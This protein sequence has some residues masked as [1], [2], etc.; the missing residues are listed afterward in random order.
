MPQVKRR[1]LLDLTPLGTPGGARGIGRYTRELARG[2]AELPPS[3]LEGIELLALTSLG[4]A[5]EYSVVSDI[6]AFLEQS[7]TSLLE[8]RDYYSWA[9]RQR[10]AMWRAAQRLRADAVH[11][12]DPHATPL[13]L[14]L[15]GTK[16][17]VTCHDIVPT[18]YP[19]HYFGWR[20]GGAAVGR[21]IEGRRY[22]SADLVIAVSDATKNDICSLLG[23]SEARVV[24][25]YNGVNVERWSGAPKLA[26]TPVLQNHGLFGRAFALY[27]GGSDWR[28]NIEGMMAAI[29]RARQSGFDLSLA[30]AG[31]LDGAHRA[32]MEGKA[33]E[34]G[35]ADVVHFLGHVTDDELAILYRAAVAHLFVSRLEG[36]GLTVV[37]A[38][39]SGCPVITT[40]GGSLAEVAGD[41]AL[42]VD[43]EDP[44]AI[45]SALGRLM[46]E[47]ECRAHLIDLG[48]ARAPR[49]SRRAQ[50]S[51]T[52]EVYRRFL[53]AE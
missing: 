53:A 36:F 16:K 43:P 25:V 17:I 31:H 51:A 34:A 28:K 14:G 35:I 9:Y 8:T 10:V 38:M 52:A 11:L 1:L 24:R 37:E 42:T 33:A 18:R 19:D 41:A 22:R 40:H 48:R 26:A 2:L 32:R 39:A 3:E 44:A 46:R 20:D 12:C 23:V 4:W 21:Y 50:A 29:A 45:A 6:A 27:V 7:G 15:T 30:W 47:P 13:L 49:F 5:G